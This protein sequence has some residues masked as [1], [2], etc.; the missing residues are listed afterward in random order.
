[1]PTKLMVAGLGVRL[2]PDPSTENEPLRKLDKGEIVDLVSES[3]DG[4]WL[5][6]TTANGTGWAWR[7]YLEIK[8][9]GNLWYPNTTVP[10]FVQPTKGKYQKGY[11]KGAVVHWIWAPQVGGVEK[12]KFWARYAISQ[13]WAFFTIGNDGSVVQSFPLDEWGNH[14]GLSYWPGLGES[15]S[16]HLVGIE[17]VC[18]G[19]VT[20]FVDGK[21]RNKV[22]NE[23]TGAI[24]YRYVEASDIRHIPAANQNIAPGYYQKY[25]AEQEQSLTNLLLWLKINNP[26]VFDL[27]LVLGHDEVAG[28]SGLG[29]H[30]PAW[31]NK[32]RKTDP[33][34]SLSMTMPEYRAFLKARYG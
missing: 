14:A 24:H 26:N 32:W 19:R 3:A 15:V 8:T 30:D 31:R 22:E 6:I 4:L 27:D 17:V 23:K 28:P 18:E 7:K 29:N 10:N 33:G 12:A 34:G 11:P 20:E 21:Y 5:Q 1:M 2:R 16:K 25:T 13:S 9:V